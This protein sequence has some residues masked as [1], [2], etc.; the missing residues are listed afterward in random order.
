[1]VSCYTGCTPVLTQPFYTFVLCILEQY[2]YCFSKP[3]CDLTSWVCKLY[4]ARFLRIRW[5]VSPQLRCTACRPS[6]NT[7]QQLHS[8]SRHEQ[9]PWNNPLPPPCCG[10]KEKPTTQDIISK[11]KESRYCS[12]VN[13]HISVGHVVQSRSK[14]RQIVYFEENKWLMVVNCSLLAI[15]V[16]MIINCSVQKFSLNKQRPLWQATFSIIGLR[17]LKEDEGVT[18]ILS[19]SNVFFLSFLCFSVLFFSSLKCAQHEFTKT[20]MLLCA[21]NTYIHVLSRFY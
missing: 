14:S 20:F 6:W 13:V 3:P 16:L 10:K 17:Y 2:A 12:G 18:N 19:F 7:W 5:R 11:W 4:P 21:R 15:H 8:G 9:V 1:M